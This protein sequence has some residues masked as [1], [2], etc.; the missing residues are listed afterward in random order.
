MEEHNNGW[1]SSKMS[2]FYQK[3]NWYLSD[4]VDTSSKDKVDNTSVRSILME[5]GVILEEEET[6]V[7]ISNESDNSDDEKVEDNINMDL[8]CKK[9][10]NIESTKILLN[11]QE[12][13][14]TVKND[15]GKNRDD[16][17][18][19][20]Y[21]DIEK[22][23]E[24]LCKMADEEYLDVCIDMSNVNNGTSQN[25]TENIS[26]ETVRNNP[27]NIKYL[28]TEK[29]TNV[30]NGETQNSKEPEI[31]EVHSKETDKQ[32]STEKYIEKC[33]NNLDKENNN[34]NLSNDNELSTNDSNNGNKDDDSQNE[35]S[36]DIFSILKAKTVKKSNLKPEKYS[37][38]RAEQKETKSDVNK[39][40][41]S[42]VTATTIKFTEDIQFANDIDE[43]G[44]F[45]VVTNKKKK[46]KRIKKGCTSES[47]GE[48]LIS[49][50]DKNKEPK[51]VKLYDNK[52]KETKV[53]D[54]TAVIGRFETCAELV[55]GQNKTLNQEKTEK[56]N[57][58]YNES[59]LNIFAPLDPN[60]HIKKQEYEKVI[61]SRRNNIEENKFS[62]Q[63][64]T[65]K[66]TTVT[67]ED[68]IEIEEKKAKQSG[69]Q[70]LIKK[71][72]LQEYI[73]REIENGG[74]MPFL[75]TPTKSIPLMKKLVENAKLRSNYG[76]KTGTKI[77]VPE[78][79][80][81]VDKK[82][83][84]RLVEIYEEHSTIW[85]PRNL[86]TIDLLQNKE[87]AIPTSKILPVTIKLSPPK[88]VK[89][90]IQP[91]RV[92]VGVISAMQKVHK[93]TY[94]SPTTKGQ[95]EII[96]NPSNVPTDD[97]LMKKYVEKSSISR[98]KMFLIRVNILSNH[99]LDKYKDSLLFRKYLST[100]NIVIDYNDLDTVDPV[101]LGFMEDI[102]PRYETL[103]LHHQRLSALLPKDTP[104]FQLNLQS[105]YGRSGE[106]C[107]VVMINCDKDNIQKLKDNFQELHDTD[108]LRFYPWKEFI[109][110]PNNLK[111]VAIKR[112]NN[113]VNSFRSVLL[114]GFIDNN[115]NV[116]MIMIDEEDENED[117]TDLLVD[118][119]YQHGFDKLSVS[120]YLSNYIFSGDGTLLFEMVYPPIDGVRETVVR[121]HHFAEALEYADLVHGELGRFMNQ[122]S[123]SLVFENPGKALNDRHGKKWE[124]HTRLRDLSEEYNKMVDS[125]PNYNKRSRSYKSQNI[126]TKSS[127][128][129]GFSYANATR[130]SEYE[131]VS[132][133][134]DSYSD[135]TDAQTTITHA[136]DITWY[137]SMQE[138]MEKMK[139]EMRAEYT[140]RFQAM[141]EENEN[142]RKDL[143]EFQRTTNDT[144]KQLVTSVNKIELIYER[145]QITNEAQFK[146]INDLLEKF[147]MISVGQKENVR[148]FTSNPNTAPI[149]APPTASKRKLVDV[150]QTSLGE[151]ALPTNKDE[152][153]YQNN[154]METDP[155]RQGYNS[156]TPL[157]AII[158]QNE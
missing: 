150:Q 13:Q 17:Y 121:K 123:I 132:F 101:H 19:E 3:W 108:M 4:Y 91:T 38:K 46:V 27:D 25:T 125:T 72:S 156:R 158:N 44:E 70:Q 151:D 76:I 21:D 133:N 42:T 124:Q 145:T 5:E 7:N 45:I 126:S 10:E 117:I 30:N 40:S 82:T 55:D 129:E 15:T 119:E 6:L 20:M 100:E 11:K 34:D 33:N 99:S 88:S 26:E 22:Y 84:Q 85:L 90:Q 53:F 32:T 41:I 74:K 138:Y 115:N 69:Q 71:L 142:L 120:D 95:A 73:L 112:Q 39:K 54:D 23:E 114:R 43:N 14:N 105:L 35:D 154:A 48:C 92:L 16:T 98:D 68:I 47:I 89:Q 97:E 65:V 93:A 146:N 1:I 107:R 110:L 28:R 136:T 80:K 37:W 135:K 140:Q 155:Q 79:N 130:E 24:Y 62:K 81:V 134:E 143:L 139:T 111:S 116:P 131:N 57:K 59:N 67:S 75:T 86:P 66:Q 87:T 102:I 157:T 83:E 51:P 103:H 127:R 128:R 63:E 36:P 77:L 104:K 152:A 149:T 144:Q 31:H 122:T 50:I 61:K 137:E 78:W 52:P 141:K 60:N 118:P 9:W 29:S 56:R 2:T 94:L 147:L 8:E 153:A 106:R 49:S 58:K 64:T 96:Y 148:P 12:Y 113:F 109:G 18:D